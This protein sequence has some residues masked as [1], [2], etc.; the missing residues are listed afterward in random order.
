MTSYTIPEKKHSTLMT[1]DVQRDFVLPGA[2]CEIAGSL[3][4][5]PTIQKLVRFYRER[6]LPIIHVVRLYLPNGSNVDLCRRHLLKEGKRIVIP[7][8]E[9]AELM[10]ELKPSSNIKLDSNRLLAGEFQEISAKEWILYKP[11][12]GAFYATPLELHLRNLGINT[13]VVSGCNFPNCPRATVYEASERDFK[14][15]FITDATSGCYDRGL[16]EL[17]N[18]GVTLTTA[19]EW[20]KNNQ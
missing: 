16:Q 11:R 9:G 14:V 19:S 3:Q 1:V 12:W 6:E 18:I 8:T 5:I 15:V 10:D 20:I 17:S 13:V 4:M 7:G 2:P